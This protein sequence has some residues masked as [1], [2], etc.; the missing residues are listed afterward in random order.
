M[1]N[2]DKAG[3]FVVAVISIQQPCYHHV[4]HY[5]VSD[6]NECSVNNGG[7]EHRCENTEGSYRC[8]CY[9][10]YRLHPN[11]RDCIGKKP[12]IEY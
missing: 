4:F 2:T 5:V 3:L 10:G 8:E 7:C 9:P 12:H 1:T 6:K 11:R